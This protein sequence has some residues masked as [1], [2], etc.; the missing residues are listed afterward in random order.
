[1]IH[2]QQLCTSWPTHQL[3]EV[4]E[5][6]DHLRVPV[7]NSERTPGPYPYYGAN[8]QQGTIDGYIFDEPLILLAEDGGHFG[9]PGRKIAYTVHGK[10]WVNNHA[11]VLRVRSGVD[12]SFLCR[13]LEEY[14]VTTFISGTTRKKL[15]KAAASRIL[16]VVPPLLEQ[17]R[18]AAILDK[19][20]AV[21][22]KR[23]NALDLADQFLRS[24]F[25][26]LFGDPVTNPKRWPVKKL[27]DVLVDIEGGWSP[28]CESRPAQGDEWGVLKLGA[29]TWG[30]YDP[31]ENKAMSTG[32]EPRVE[33][34]VRNGDLLFARKNTYDLVGASAYVF[35]TPPRL[36]L[37]DLI[38]RL[39]TD[40]SVDSVYL[41]MV[42]SHPG[43]RESL[44]RIASGSAGSM[45]NISKGR[46]KERAI[47][48]PP[49]E[50]QK[51]LT[52]LAE[53]HCNALV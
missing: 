1:M 45:P 50:L 4:V 42:L 39:V 30:I 41:W 47:P 15:T 34:E 18:I 13:Q 8:G 33:L 29:V 2:A 22:R 7:K 38:F 12:I 46:L 11:H 16:V 44:R 36:T 53:H 43:T 48:V 52:Q 51:P 17:R 6:L 28:K 14:D 9:M 25:L 40:V 35:E 10:C 19:A 23:Q 27:G 37:P 26:D 49:L 21:C 31:Q 24:A 32:T 3:S 20:D 5:F